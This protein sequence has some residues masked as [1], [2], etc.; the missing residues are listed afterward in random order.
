LARHDHSWQSV[1]PAHRRGDR[2]SAYLHRRTWL[3][4]KT[5]ID[6]RGS[7]CVFGGCWKGFRD[8]GAGN[9]Y[10]SAALAGIDQFT[11]W[12]KS[13][14]PALKIPHHDSLHTIYLTSTCFPLQIV[15]SYCSPFCCR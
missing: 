3:L 9:S 8:P 5:T 11:V 15:R 2:L 12:P 7:K 1:V 14:E 13:A 4:T 10:I 6:R